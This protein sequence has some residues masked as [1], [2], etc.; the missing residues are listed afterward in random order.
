MREADYEN[1]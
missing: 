1:M